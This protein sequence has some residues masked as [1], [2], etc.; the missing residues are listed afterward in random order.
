ML[1]VGLDKYRT[2]HAV[3]LWDVLKSGTRP[4]GELGLSDTTH[5]LAWIS[6]H[7]RTLAM[8][9]NCKHLRL[10]DLRGKPSKLSEVEIKISTKSNISVQKLCRF[11]NNHL[12]IYLIITF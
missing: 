8:G 4:I 12:F 11:L 1:A 10:V 6:H 7:P 2:D 9:V 3:L 5:T